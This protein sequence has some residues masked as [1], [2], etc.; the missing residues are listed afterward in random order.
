[1]AYRLLLR[2]SVAVLL[3]LSAVAGARA[4]CPDVAFSYSAQLGASIAQGVKAADADCTEGDPMTGACNSFVG[5]VLDKTYGYR[6][7]KLADRYM[8][9]SELN[10]FLPSSSTWTLMGYAGEQL[11]LNQAQLDANN[12]AP[13]IAISHDQVAL[14]LPSRELFHSPAWNLCVPLSAGHVLG[15]AS[16]NYTSG[17]LSTPWGTPHGVVIWER[18]GPLVPHM[19]SLPPATAPRPPSPPPP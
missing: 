9:V 5:R 4:S 3:P 6:D 10:A 17:L 15:D 8:N 19:Q 12:G 14:V 11:V 7:F 13:V 18:S 1:M 16:Q 2:V